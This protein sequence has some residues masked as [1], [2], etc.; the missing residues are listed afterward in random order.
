MVR[1]WILRWLLNILALILTAVLLGSHFELTIWAAIVGSVF[2][3]IV[4][5]LIR[6]ILIGLTLPLNILTLGLF[7]LVINGFLMWI[8]AVTVPHVPHLRRAKWP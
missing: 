2:L 4:N 1:G 8:T 6:P 3:G 7:T 5:A